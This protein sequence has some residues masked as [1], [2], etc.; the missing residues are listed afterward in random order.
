MN[1][2][3]KILCVP[4]AST[5]GNA[6]KNAERVISLAHAVAES[7]ANP[8]VIVLPELALS[9]YLIESL[10]AESAVDEAAILSLANDLTQ[11]GLK[12]KTEWVIGVPLREGNEIYNAAVVLVDGKICHIHRKLFLPTYGMFDEAR[13]FTRGIS[14]AT[15]DGVLGKTAILICEDAWHL[16]MLYAAAVTQAGAVVVISSS[17]A[18]GY[19]RG[20]EA[21]DSTLT[22]RDRL[23]IAVESYGQTYIYCNR[24]GVEDGI[25]YDGSNFVIGDGGFRDAA[26]VAVYD[27]ANLYQVPAT[28]QRHMGL[29]GD[30]SRQNDLAL[31]REILR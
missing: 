14:F 6:N 25:L 26:P 22:W 17:P 24:S 28:F 20:G 30:S 23:R 10:V 31:M 13:Y 27:K 7:G 15:Y 18:R 4:F 5:L 29:K 16:E 2:D 12:A 11:A 21:F 3:K 1:P 9:G 8:D 19:A